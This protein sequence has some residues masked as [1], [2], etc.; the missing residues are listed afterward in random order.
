[1]KEVITPKFRKASISAK[2]IENPERFLAVVVIHQA[3][4]DASRPGRGRGNWA[5]R[6]LVNGETLE[7]WRDAA[8]IDEEALNDAVNKYFPNSK[9]E[10][11]GGN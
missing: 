11:K 10:R 1:M 2:N 5:L 6:W 3:F 8:E 4:A 9:I 7:F